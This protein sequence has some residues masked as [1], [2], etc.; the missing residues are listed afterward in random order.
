MRALEAFP[1]RFGVLAVS[2]RSLGPSYGW[3]Q[4]I[5]FVA[6]AALSFGVLGASGDRAAF[7][8][9]NLFDFY[10]R[11][12]PSV[13]APVG[14]PVELVD[15]D[16]ET[17]SRTGPWPWPRTR[18]ADLVGKISDG[19]AKA[20]VIAAPI[21][22]RDPFSPEVIGAEWLKLDNDPALQQALTRLPDPDTALANALLQTTAAYAV[23]AQPTLG[24]FQ[25]SA[26][27]RADTSGLAWLNPTG[28]AVEFLALPPA[29][30]DFPA[31]AA[32][33]QA[34]QPTVAAL[35]V[36]ADGAFR[37][38]ALLWEDDG[39]PVPALALEAA[40]LAAGEPVAPVANPN[41]LFGV[42][43]A[44][45]AISI[46]ALKIGVRDGAT[47]RFYP[48]RRFAADATPAWRILESPAAA[49]ALKDAVVIVGVSG[50]GAPL[51]RTSRGEARPAVVQTLLARQIL[52]GESLVRPQW[53]ALAEI[54]SVIL[55]GLIGFFAARA[56]RFWTAT[57]ATGVLV[58]G[59][60]G[61]SW[62]LFAAN[63][64]LVDPLPGVAAGMISILSV[65]G[66]RI[67]GEVLRHG[68]VYGPFQGT[69]PPAAMKL[70]ADKGAFHILNGVRRDLT[71]LSCEVRCAGADAS[72]AEADPDALARLVAAANSHMRRRI[73]DAGG[74]VDQAEGGRLIAY[75]NAPLEAADH[76]QAACSCALS[77]IDSLD[78]L[79]SEL[80]TAADAR[81]ERPL[82]ARLA[83]G[84]TS[85]DCYAGAMGLG[86]RNRYSAVG[87]PVDLATFLRAR[88]RIYGPA[89][90]CNQSVYDAAHHRFAFLEADLVHVDGDAAPQHI[91]AL[92]GNPFVKA[93]PGYRQLAETQR[94][95]LAAF[96]ASDWA[97]ARTL[98][99]RLRE[100]SG[101]QAALYNLYEAR[102]AAFERAAPP[103]DWSGAEAV[104]F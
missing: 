81:G 25:A 45:D 36:D 77:I 83:F 71:I 96:R 17:L 58:V 53:A 61:A 101:A 52:S 69:L 72:L 50:A 103:Q 94:A 92:V 35:P 87:A 19:G 13:A 38:T 86:A 21:A 47:F 48:P 54:G 24:V 89:I 93:S 1:A 49:S 65:A 56:L 97:Q 3:L 12:H 88:S 102:I 63:G 95:M 6:M 91:Y 22:G 44:L 76:V 27:E 74:A 31:P 79:N 57:A 32:I 60:F 90:I 66:A 40:R 42:G 98:I 29:Q 34:A 26:A 85:G 5:P 67:G 8:R 23:D 14:A 18:M 43:H 78:D 30:P 75:W 64:L 100:T 39:R 11:L 10:A 73:L 7:P 99:E 9:E 82:Y 46:G 2:E 15:I 59:A 80:E 62:T 84:L 70:L 16:A 104:T 4:A 68:A 20:V 55:L 41:T 33:A 37:R 28:A 51:V